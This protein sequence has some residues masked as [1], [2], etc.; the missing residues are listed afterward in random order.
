MQQRHGVLLGASTVA[1]GTSDRQRD[2]AE[3]RGLGI[4]IVVGDR[5]SSSVDELAEIFAQYDTVIGCAGYAASI[6]TPMNSAR[7]ALQ[8]RIPRYFPWQFGVDFDVI[9]RRIQL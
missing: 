5:L 2:I 4:E 8:A 1:S 6:D 7:A 3:I 9:V